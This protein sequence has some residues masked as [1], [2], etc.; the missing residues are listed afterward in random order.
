VIKLP[1]GIIHSDGRRVDVVV[2]PATQVAFEREFTVAIAAAF[3]ESPRMEH[4]Y[5]MAWHAAKSGLPFE[6]WIESV[7]GLDVGEV[8]TV[9]PSLPT[10]SA[11]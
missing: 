1:I 11:G 2:R 3:A 9:N 10:A 8:E 7:D 5:F 4:I 6:E